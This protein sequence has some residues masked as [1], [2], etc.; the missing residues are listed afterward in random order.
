MGALATSASTNLYKS[1]VKLKDLPANHRRN[2]CVHRNTDVKSREEN[3]SE[4]DHVLRK[5][6]YGNRVMR[7]YAK[8]QQSTLHRDDKE[9]RVQVYSR[10][11]HNQGEIGAT[12]DNDAADRK[13]GREERVVKAKVNEAPMNCVHVRR[14]DVVGGTGKD[15]SNL[16]DQQTDRAHRT[17]E[18]WPRLQGMASNNEMVRH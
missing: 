7:K 12:Q 10:A 13:R 16:P 4:C 11:R 18:L 9:G 8:R 2:M 3:K 1:R 15:P 17:D 5:E 6:L 14:E